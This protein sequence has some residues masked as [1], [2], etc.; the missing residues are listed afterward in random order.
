[1]EVDAA[2]QVAHAISTHE[3]EPEM[4]F[5]TAVDDLQPEAEHFTP[6]Q[7][8]MGK[9][10]YEVKY[11]CQACHTIGSSGGYVGPSLNDAGNWMNAGW[12]EEWLR[13]PQSLVPGAAEPRRSFTEEEV[14]ALTAYLMTLRQSP[15][16]KTLIAGR[17]AR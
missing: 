15:G 8:A 2:C 17:G 14:K 16:S 10:L 4:D 6:A 13:N 1:M 11:Q 9:Q 12:I 3:A 7:V 5:F